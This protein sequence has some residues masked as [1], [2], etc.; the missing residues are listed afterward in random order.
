[1]GD[2]TFSPGGTGQATVPKKAFIRQFATMYPVIITNEFRT[3]KLHPLS[4]LEL[5]DIKTDKDTKTKERLRPLLVTPP[6]TKKP[7]LM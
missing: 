6:P 3:S 5:T 4:F 7:E 2:G 1:M